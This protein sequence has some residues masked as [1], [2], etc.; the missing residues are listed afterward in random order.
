MQK[1]YIQTLQAQ[2]TRFLRG[3]PSRCEKEKT[4][5]LQF[6][7]TIPLSTITGIHNSSLV[8][9]RGIQSTTIFKK[10]NSLVQINF[11]KM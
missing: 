10:Y 6:T 8:S 3:K 1:I 11:Y 5:G 9:T 7:Q 4:T 2:D